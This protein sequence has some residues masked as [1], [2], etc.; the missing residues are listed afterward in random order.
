VSRG[1]GDRA[2]DLVVL[3]PDGDRVALASFAGEA[4]TLIFLRHLG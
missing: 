4:T 1:V 3:A 2:G